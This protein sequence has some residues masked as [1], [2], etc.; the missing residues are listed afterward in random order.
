VNIS[1]IILKL[2]ALMATTVLSAFIIFTR[3]ELKNGKEKILNR[4]H[5][6]VAAT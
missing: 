5:S 4:L 2:L 3:S 6:Q 1:I